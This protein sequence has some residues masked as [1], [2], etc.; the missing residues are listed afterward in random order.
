MAPG[1]AKRSERGERVPW[2]ANSIRHFM[3]CLK[4]TL[5]TC[6]LVPPAWCGKRVPQDNLKQK[7]AF[8]QLER[9]MQVKFKVREKGWVGEWRLIDD[10]CEDVTQK[11]TLPSTTV[12]D[13]WF[14]R[15]SR[16]A[17]INSVWSAWYCYRFE[18]L[19]LSFVGKQIKAV[20]STTEHPKITGYISFHSVPWH[21]TVGPTFLP[22]SFF[23][24]V[25]N[26]VYLGGGFKYFLFSTLFGEDS[27]FD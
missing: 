19:P 8:V 26:H 11:S 22:V 14:A 15:L 27:N 25:L 7:R 18:K 16:H 9:L 23:E 21:A 2:G 24:N 6:N 10:V 1:A 4:S 13:H 5:L 3:D 20:I 12:E 17:E